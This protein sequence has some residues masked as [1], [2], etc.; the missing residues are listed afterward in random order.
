M[1]NPTKK[2]RAPSISLGSEQ[3]EP[4]TLL[5]VTASLSPAGD[6][7]VRGDGAN[8]SVSLTPYRDSIRVGSS[9]GVAYFKTA[10]VRSILVDLGGGNDRFTANGVGTPAMK[11]TVKMGGGRNEA[12]TIANS[13]FASLVLDATPSLNTKV[14]LNRA[15]A[16]A[17]TCLFGNDGGHDR[18]TIVNSRVNDVHAS[19]GGGNDRVAAARSTIGT[20][21]VDLGGGNDFLSVGTNSNVNLL[22][23]HLGSGYAEKVSL[24]HSSINTASIDAAASVATAVS[25]YKLR[26][27][28]SMS[29]NFGNDNGNDRLRLR[30][31]AFGSLSA[32][33]GGGN[34]F[35]DAYRSRLNSANLYMGGG[36]DKVSVRANSSVNG[37]LKMNMGTGS[38]EVV[39]LVGSSFGSVAI[40]AQASLGTRVA[41]SNGASARSLRANFG[42]DSG[43]DR[44]IL[45]RATVNNLNA[46]LGNG[47]DGVHV[48]E[49]SRVSYASLDLGGGNDF[50]RVTGSVVN[51]LANGGSGSDRI[52]APSRLKRVAFERWF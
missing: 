41:F 23:A 52:S 26:N 51:G 33:M 44:L 3:L 17:L 42:S 46:T 36:R 9:S 15:R 32:S 13:T 40:D 50:L 30:D 24:A 47:N 10:S 25:T 1:R 31:S 39:S 21:A 48:I 43:S 4:R 20:L 16:T 2:R 18:L 19:M 14:T 5:A 29:C 12:L 34:D 27:A 37:S 11:A 35:F 49:G 22:K 8:D 28:S 6:L 45:R 38:R 7:A